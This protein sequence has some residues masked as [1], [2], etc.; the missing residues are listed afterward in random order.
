MSGTEEDCEGRGLGPRGRDQQEHVAPERSTSQPD[1]RIT[2]RLGQNKP[3][4][5]DHGKGK[6]GAAAYRRMPRVAGAVHITGAARSRQP[7]PDT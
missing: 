3:R 4:E 1:G 7:T 5:G 6:A 2:V